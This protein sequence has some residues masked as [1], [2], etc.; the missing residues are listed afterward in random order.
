MNACEYSKYILNANIFNNTIK[1]NVQ[2]LHLLTMTNIGLS[3]MD[4]GVWG[5]TPAAGGV[6]RQSPQETKLGKR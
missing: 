6:K 5:G 2:K 4:G 3:K 1:T